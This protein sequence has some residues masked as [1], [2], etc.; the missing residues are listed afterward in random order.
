[1]KFE[2]IRK[3][4]DIPTLQQG[5]FK[6]KHIDILEGQEITEELVT[7][8]CQAIPEGIAAYLSL[9]PNGEDQ[10]MEVLCENG[11]MAL[12]YFDEEHGNYYY[13]YNEKYAGSDELAPMPGQSPVEKYLAL[14]DL[15]LGIKCVDYFIRTGEFYPGIEWA[16][17]I[18]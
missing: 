11:W 2:I 15:A 13:S 4:D 7:K 9:D 5:I 18:D 16:K 8:F 12:G 17:Q 3:R 6:V 1:M 10:C 14:E